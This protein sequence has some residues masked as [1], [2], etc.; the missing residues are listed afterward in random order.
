MTLPPVRQVRQPLQ[1][2]DIILR[3]A[4]D[5]FMSD[6][7]NPSRFF[8]T[9][10]LLSA[11]PWRA[12]GAGTER[13]LLPSIDVSE[14]DKEMTVVANIPGYDPKNVKAEIKDN[15][16]VMQGSME[17]EKQE[18][19]RRWHRQERRSGSFYREI[20]LPSVDEAKA[21]CIM[22]NGTLT[23]TVP[24]KEEA[25]GKNLPIEIAS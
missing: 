12:M 4:V 9:S 21:R 8:D 1:S 19:G 5:R 23:V 18:K 11:S 6:A 25:K 13:D 10:F 3:D 7:L 24:K 22:K 17:E 2:P 14:T 15:C 16:L 20:G